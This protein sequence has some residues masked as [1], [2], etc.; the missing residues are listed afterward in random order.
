L[1]SPIIEQRSH[2]LEL[3][4][5]TADLLLEA[6]PI[7]LSQVITNL[8][9]NA[10]RYTEPGG[11]IWVSA[12]REDG[13][14]ILRV[15]D[16][17]IGITS[18]LLPRIFDLFSQGTRGFDRSQG[19][20]GLG[21]TIVKS[22][23]AV[24]GGSVRAESQ[25]IGKGSQFEIRL[26]AIEAA[27]SRVA[28]SCERRLSAARRA[29]LS[30]RVLIVD[31]NEDAATTLSEMLDEIGYSTRV[32]FDARSALQIVSEFV[33]DIMLVDIGLPVM[34][35][36]QL[37]RQLRQMPEL[38]SVRLLA[39]TGYGQESD[40]QRALRSG[41]DDHLVKPIDMEALLSILRETRSTS[42]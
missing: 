29:P 13:E 18:E 21:L 1:A 28:P 41:F 5:P 15:R 20:L 35:G 34:D 33:P 42:V 16:N 24:H 6:D 12:A 4:V 19:G 38:I 30:T 10:A 27:Q 39:L 25:G 23:V 26:P 3:S 17:G 9:T 37:A 36:Y 31:D 14:I 2:H 8:L 7:R 22:L 40:R 32:S 11:R